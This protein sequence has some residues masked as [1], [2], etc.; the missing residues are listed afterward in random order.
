MKSRYQHEN[1]RLFEIEEFKEREV[2]PGDKV[3]TPLGPGIIVK[4]GSE[5]FLVKVDPLIDS[6]YFRT[7]QADQGGLYFLQEDMESEK[8]VKRQIELSF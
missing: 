8:K 7:L 2:N 3:K 1:I 6:T 4:Q 5:R